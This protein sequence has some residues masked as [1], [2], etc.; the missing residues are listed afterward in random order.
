MNPFDLFEEIRIINLVDNDVRML[1]I[2]DEMNEMG[3][4]FKRF[5]AIKRNPGNVGATLSHKQC[6]IEAKE[7]N[8]NNILI[9]EDDC[10]FM[11]DKKRTHEQL[12]TALNY[13]KDKDWDI[14]YFGINCVEVGDK[15]NNVI[16]PLCEGLYK[17]RAGYGAFAYVVN[18]TVFDYFLSL[19]PENESD[20]NIQNQTI[21]DQILRFKLALRLKMYLTPLVLM[22]ENNI[23]DNEK[24]AVNYNIHIL[25]RYKKYG[26]QI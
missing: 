22:Q 20:I 5:N 11:Y 7:K 25:A 24:C 3:V 19:F 2:T 16:E 23:S 8:K 9:F 13:L 15:P 6:I 26:V 10:V 18:G 1:E 12:N 14:L 21:V 4:K 17:V